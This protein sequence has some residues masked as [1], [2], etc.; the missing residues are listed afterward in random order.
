[1]QQGLSDDEIAER[2]EVKVETSA[3]NLRKIRQRARDNGYL[4]RPETEKRDAP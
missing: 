4:P 3:E 1:M 2:Q